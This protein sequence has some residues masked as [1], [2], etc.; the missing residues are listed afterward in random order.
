[1][2]IA[3]PRVERK[4]VS[5]YVKIITWRMNANDHDE[6]T[7]GSFEERRHLTKRDWNNN[8]PYHVQQLTCIC[9]GRP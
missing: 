5:K 8:G 7:H 4:K 1:M 2:A 3:D 9:L 6:V